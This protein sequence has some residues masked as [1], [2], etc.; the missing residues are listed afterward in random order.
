MKLNKLIKSRESWGVGIVIV[1]IMLVLLLVIPL[2]AII[3][4]I[5]MAMNL[6]LALAVFLA[7][8]FTGC[9]HRAKGKEEKII[10]GKMD[11]FHF[12]P[13]IL[14]VYIFFGLEVYIS[15]IRLILSKGAEV[16]SKMLL[17]V[18]G[19]VNTDGIAGIIV[20]FVSLIFLFG[21][22][23]VLVVRNSTYLAETAARFALDTMPEAMIAMECT[24]TCGEI[25]EEMFIARKDYMIR[26]NDFLGAIDGVGN[27]LVGSV[28]IAI[29]LIV[30]SILG[31]II[32]GT[33][34]HGQTV[35]EAVK[36]FIAFSISGG[37]I[38]LPPPLLL[39]ITINIVSS[40]V[41]AIS[42]LKTMNTKRV[43]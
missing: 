17:F 6:F 39:S 34:F 18:S 8:V 35:Q 11:I 32:I 43:I 10:P 9:Q 2:P 33:M 30:V 29:H 21:L 28:K 31:G 14:L 27:F 37:I 42:V 3:L 26:Q 41:Y 22:A 12:F 20:G 23:M 38:F 15:S 5:L 1:V 24:Y 36:T 4:D 7:I 13:T 40:R 19:P 25:S 16:D